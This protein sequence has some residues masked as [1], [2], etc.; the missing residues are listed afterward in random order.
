ME[1]HEVPVWKVR[2]LAA[3]AGTTASLAL[4]LFT[5]ITL[6][7]FVIGLVGMPVGAVVGAIF[8]PLILAARRPWPLVIAAGVVSAVAG[9]L[10]YVAFATLQQSGG[11]TLTD[12]V[13]YAL[14]TAGYAVVVSLTLGLVMSIVGAALATNWLRR[15]MA[16][17]DR[18]VVGAIVIVGLTIAG[19]TLAF[20]TAAR[21]AGSLAAVA[22]DSVAIEYVVRADPATPSGLLLETRSYWRGELWGSSTGAIGDCALGS[23][24]VQS[25]WAI[26]VTPN[27]GT[28]RDRP[29]GPPL[30]TNRDIPDQPVRLTVVID[31]T[32]VASWEPGLRLAGC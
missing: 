24:V 29:D 30:V 5:F 19:T 15:S 23:D 14:Q 22:G 18:F 8:G 3:A 25:D 20:A 13:D 4:A 21:G 17:P 27:D 6:V 26:W 7:G 32:G 11:A 12:L 1:L 28:W 9:C 31:R 16:N 10:T 2:L